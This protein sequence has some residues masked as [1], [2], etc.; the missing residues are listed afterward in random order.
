MADIYT[1]PRVS[2]KTTA[3]PHSSVAPAAEDTTVLFVPIATKKG[4]EGLCQS[5]IHSLSEFISIYGELD[6]EVNGQMALNV[7]NWL[8]NGG[9]VCVYRLNLYTKAIGGTKEDEE[10]GIQY[11]EAKYSGPFYNSLEVTIAART[12]DKSS[13]NVTVLLDGRAVE[14]F[15]G[16]TEKN[17]FSA[18]S[19]SEYITF[20]KTDYD[21]KTSLGNEK[22]ETFKIYSD[23]VPVATKVSESDA[24]KEFWSNELTDAETPSGSAGNTYTDNFK[25]KVLRNPLVPNVDMIM[26]AGYSADIKKLMLKFLCG[27]S[28]SGTKAFRPDLIGIFDN[29]VLN[30]KLT[31]PTLS[32]STT[33]IFP[34]AT[35]IAV[36]EQYFTISDAIF[37]DQDIYVCPSYFLSKLIPYNDLQYGI[38]YATAGLRRGVLDDA[39]AIN[40]N[41]MPSEKQA[42]FEDRINYV[43]KTAREYSF[44][45]QRTH[46]GSNEEIYTALSFLNNVR[47][48][49]KM[50]KDIR[51]LGREYLFEFNDSTT[52]S[53]MSN[54]LN[55][56][57]TNWVANRTLSSGVVTVSKNP[58]SDEAVDVEITIKFNGTIEVISVN[59][60]IE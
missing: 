24:I 31:A 42:W 46:D 16:L 43:E 18:L 47:V 7:Y 45:S 44:M 8:R 23:S 21:F 51:N 9:T 27:D 14:Q 12:S 54:V 5:N 1:Y 11:F 17:F 13:V 57:I 38:Q 59:I 55:K 20:T 19:G 22:S 34:N 49:E 50:K 33:S 2:I 10:D 56:Y 28:T 25:N 30:G 48:L 58:Y 32:S 40:K 36:Y 52:L 6:Y 26:D 39:I 53:K 29:Y 60:T 15:Y 37:T 3:K 4:P 41:P 35:N